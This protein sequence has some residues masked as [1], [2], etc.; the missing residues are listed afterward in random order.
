MRRGSIA[1]GI[2]TIAFLAC[3]SGEALR[4]QQDPYGQF[5]ATTPP[6]SPTDEQKCFHLP[7]D[8]SIELVASEPDIGKP[9]NMN[10]DDR[11]RLW[12]S[13]SVEYPFPAPPGRTPRDAVKILEDTDGDGKA[14]KFITFADG[15]NIPIGVLPMT[16]GAIVH[17]IPNVYRMT[18]RHGS[19]RA[20]QREIL[21][22]SIGYADTHGMTSSFTW[23]FDGWIYACHGFAN[24]SVIKGGDGS[25]ITMHSGNTYRMKPDG[26][27]VEQFTHGQVNPFGLCFDPLGNLYSADCETKPVTML[28]RGGYYSSFGKPHD[29]LGFAPEMCDH[30]HGS[31]AVG[32]IVYYAADGFPP[33]YRDNIFTGNV[34]TNR[35]NRDRLERQGS[36]LKAIHQP[37]FLTCDDLWFRPV[38]IKLGLDGA[39]Y[40]ADFYNRIIGHYEVPLTH[41]GRDKERGRIWRIVYRGPDRKTKPVQPRPDWSKATV[42][43]LVSDLAH[44]NLVVRMKATNQLVERGG[45]EGV[46]AVRQIMVP[47]SVPFQRMHGLW[48]L[49]R[50]NALDDKQLEAAVNDKDSGVRVHAMHVLAERRPLRDTQLAWVRTALRDPDAFVKR[51]AADALGTHPMAEN[52]KPLLELRNAVPSDDAH[53]L[54]TVRMALRNQLLSATAWAKLSDTTL[55]ESALHLVADVAPGTP[56]AEAASFLLN[57]LRLA[58]PET[59]DNVLRYVHHIARYGNADTEPTLLALV[60]NHRPTDISQQAALFKAIQQGTQERGGK[61]STAAGQWAAELANTLL[62]SNQAKAIVTG[63][64]LAGSLR[65]EALREVLLAI[66]KKRDRPDIARRASIEALM[67]ID[68]KGNV[69]VLGQLLADATEPMSLREQVAQVLAGSNRRDAQTELLKVLA[70]APARLQN[71]IATGLANSPQGANQLL[72]AVATGKA[73]A[74]LLQERAVRVRLDRQPKLKERLAQLTQGLPSSDQRLEELLRKRRSGFLAAKTDAALG[75]RVFE[76]SC[77]NCHQIAGKGTKVGPQLDGIGAR[78]VDRLLEDILDPNRNVDQAFRATTLALKTGQIVAGLVLREEGEV[79]VLADAQGKEVRVPKSAIEERTV[80]QLSPMPANLV[81]QIP[82]ADFYHLLAYLLSQ[83]AGSNGKPAN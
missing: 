42:P 65:I 41:P 67:A 43:E 17:S 34:V 55:S 50:L 40:V 15:L 36:T 45:P 21:Y 23:G 11:G 73:S 44:P 76:K 33:E 68:P 4:S 38:D 64:E 70:I 83:R 56:T 80:S 16:N 35:I 51:A 22:G 61:L 24:T 71:T 66:A 75:A 74:R 9:I 31:T 63:A 3:W 78:G 48:V 81:D 18:A 13:Q 57:Y 53:L 19:D 82:E 49:E 46:A 25:A 26:S 58:L 52:V 7:P 10:F 5:I 72:E 60:R 37:D 62:S 27:H 59:G 47:A 69:V 6:R 8:F 39:L 79:V 77:A 54:Y 28:L 29:G 12:I 2:L 14:D 20:D 32:G 1:S 30:M